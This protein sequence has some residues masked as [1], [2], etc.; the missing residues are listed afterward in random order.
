MQHRQ[1]QMWGAPEP[2]VGI[3]LGSGGSAHTMTSHA[4]MTAFEYRTRL[5]RPMCLLEIRD[6]SARVTYSAIGDAR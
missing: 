1:T 2:A 4:P 5:L 6:G 3:S